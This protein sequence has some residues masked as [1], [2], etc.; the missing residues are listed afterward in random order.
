[1]FGI[2]VILGAIYFPETNAVTEYRLEVVHAATGAVIIDVPLLDGEKFQIHY[3]HSVDGLPVR[4]TF[5]AEQGQLVLDGVHWMSFGAGLGYMGQGDIRVEA[6]WII[7]ENMNR[8]V[9]ELLLRVGTVA[10]H[11][12]VYRGEEYP[13]RDYVEGM[14][15][16]RLS[17]TQQSK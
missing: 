16:L 5:R 10:D 8:R 2:V 13:L 15:L 3:T 9:G 6:E 1:M 7:I 14:E 4:E 17:V 12:L 11:R